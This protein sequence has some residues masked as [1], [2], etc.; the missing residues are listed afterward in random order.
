MNRAMMKIGTLG[1]KPLPS[2]DTRKSTPTARS[3]GRRPKR[4][5]GQEPMSEPSTVPYR[6]APIATPCT[7]ALRFH[8]RWIVCSAPEMTTVS[9]PKRKPAS[10]DVRDQ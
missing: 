6:A 3:V 10:A 2:A 7:A 4:S 8:N 9:K 5:A 1:A